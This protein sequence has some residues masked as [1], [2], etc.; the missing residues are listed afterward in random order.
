[1]TMM[2]ITAMILATGP[3]TDWRICWSGCSQGMLEPAAQAGAL[4]NITRATA[5]V[6]RRMRQAE[7]IMA[8][9]LWR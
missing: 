1:M 5:G 6:A 8:G 4:V 3:S 7:G 9:L 2:M